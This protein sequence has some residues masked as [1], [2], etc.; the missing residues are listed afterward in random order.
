MSN[1]KC[2][3]R[4]VLKRRSLMILGKRYQTQKRLKKE[5]QVIGTK[6]VFHLIYSMHTPCL[7]KDNFHGFCPQWILFFSFIF[8]SGFSPCLL[9]ENFHGF[10]PQWSFIFIPSGFIPCLL[11]ESFH[12]LLPSVVFHFYPQ[13]I[14]C[15]LREYYHRFYPQRFLFSFYF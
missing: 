11:R 9:R 6:Y 8:P 1:K 14:L 10:C 5:S 3:D 15:L 12:R 2:Y 4:S 13:W 7:L